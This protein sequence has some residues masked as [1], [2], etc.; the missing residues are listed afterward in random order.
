MKKIILS[1]IISIVLVFANGI[2][3]VFDGQFNTMSKINNNIPISFYEKCSI[4]SMF[5][6]IYMFGW[7]YSPEAAY[8]NFLMSFPH[9]S[10]T[11]YYET[12]CWLTPKITNRIK[13]HKFGKVTWRGNP[14]NNH[15]GDYNMM[16][17]EHRAAI[18]LNWCT[19]SEDS[20]YYYA[21]CDYTYKVPSKTEFYMKGFKIIINENLFYELEKCR[22]I[23]PYKLVCY[24]SKNKL[25]TD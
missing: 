10:D 12:D 23:Y 20:N 17:P 4:Y 24:C 3:Y 19:I 25:E 8:C 6:A 13:N 2:Y 15:I 5:M 7:I 9:K 18:L 22:W 1:L 16:S 21:T 11:I 14:Y